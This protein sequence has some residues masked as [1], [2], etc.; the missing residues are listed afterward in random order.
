[1]RERKKK[2]PVKGLK[3]RVVQWFPGIGCQNCPRLHPRLGCF[4]ESNLRGW[5]TSP[6]ETYPPPP[7]GLGSHLNQAKSNNLTIMI[8]GYFSLQTCVKAPWADDKRWRVELTSEWTMHV[9]AGD[10]SSPLWSM[11]VNALCDSE[12]WLFDPEAHEVLVVDSCIA[13][14][15]LLGISQSACNFSRNVY[16]SA[17]YTR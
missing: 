12:E 5:C 4:S 14:F 1:M 15:Y 2:I 17:I 8:P 11:G 7:P 9:R 3:I 16:S 10:W 13:M 6:N